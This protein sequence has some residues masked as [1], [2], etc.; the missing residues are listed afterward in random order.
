MIKETSACLWRLNNSN[1][2]MQAGLE[3]NKEAGRMDVEWT[4]GDFIFITM[5][6]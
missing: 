3:N 5:I 4:M 6:F 1:L 2:N